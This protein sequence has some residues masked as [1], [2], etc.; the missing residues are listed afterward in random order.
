M[1]LRCTSPPV[2]GFSTVPERSSMKGQTFEERGAWCVFSEL[3]S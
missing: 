3:V 2:D 1:G